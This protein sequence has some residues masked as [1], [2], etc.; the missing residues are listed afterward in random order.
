MTETGNE[1]IFWLNLSYLQALVEAA[2]AME[3]V[4]GVWVDWEKLA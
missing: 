2:A 4:C 1:V 3:S